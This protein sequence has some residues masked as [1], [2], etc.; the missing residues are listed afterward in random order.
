MHAS[1]TYPA[2]I[3]TAYINHTQHYLWKRLRQHLVT[4]IT[5]IAATSHRLPT[6]DWIEDL[7]YERM[8]QGVFHVYT[9]QAAG[10]GDTSME[11]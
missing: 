8:N 1:R 3:I 2:P 10:E 5:Q 6:H 11:G 7:I 4:A 9:S